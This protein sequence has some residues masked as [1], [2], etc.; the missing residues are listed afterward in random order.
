MKQPKPGDFGLTKIKGFL[1]F[2]VGFGQFLTGDSSRYTHAFIVL[3]DNR[4][5]EAMP[6]GAKISSIDQYR[7][8]AIYSNIELTDQQRE[9]IVKYAKKYENV[10]YSFLDYLSLA[11]L[12][13]GIKPKKLRNFIQNKG[14]MICS[15][16]VDHVYY[17]AGVHLFNDGRLPQD[18]TPGDLANRLIE[19][20]W[21]E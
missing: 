6:G 15:Q 5:I 11:L 13:F 10:K 8:K 16:L 17:L 4:I 2:M 1:G 3:D 12:R 21:I 9:D 19:A 20:D 14:H 18:V 7:N